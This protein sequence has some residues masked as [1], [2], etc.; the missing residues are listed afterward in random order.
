MGH[1]E[2]P[3]KSFKDYLFERESTCKEEQR[4]K[5]QTKSW[6]L[7]QATQVPL[8]YFSL[9]TPFLSMTIHI[10]GSLFNCYLLLHYMSAT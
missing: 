5:S 6:L 4:D 8:N 2:L 7:N 3:S 1:F 10:D 9:K